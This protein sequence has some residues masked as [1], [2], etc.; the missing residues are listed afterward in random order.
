MWATERA[1]VVAG[2]GKKVEGAAKR[3]VKGKATGGTTTSSGGKGGTRKK[4]KGGGKVERAA[5]EILK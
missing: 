5:R 1:S 2:I 4:G 3:A